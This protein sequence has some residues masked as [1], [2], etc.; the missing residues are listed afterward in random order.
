MRPDVRRKAE[1]KQA[2]VREKRDSMSRTFEHGHTVA[3]RDY[4]QYYSRWTTGTI[5]AQSGP[6]SYSVEIASG[7]KWRRH[8]DQIRSLNTPIQQDA[9]V[10]VSKPT[11]KPDI[12]FF[13]MIHL[14]LI[15]NHLLHL[16]QAVDI[17]F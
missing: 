3:V 15:K 11:V 6:V 1:L 5:K 8:A 10:Q 16:R 2:E 17:Q 14:C 12:S 4:R 13:H 9:D 7:S